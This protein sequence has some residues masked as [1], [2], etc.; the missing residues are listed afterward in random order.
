MIA[1]RPAGKTGNCRTLHVLTPERPAFLL[2]RKLPVTHEAWRVD[3][4]KADGFCFPLMVFRTGK[5][6]RIFGF[7]RA[8]RLDVEVRTWL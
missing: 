5:E 7:T 2:V 1:A 8:R 4:C 6:A 3:A